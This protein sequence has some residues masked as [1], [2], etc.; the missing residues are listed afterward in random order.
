MKCL[1]PLCRFNFDEGTPPTNFDT[2][3]AA[4]MTVFQVQPSPSPM[5]AGPYRE[6]PEFI[7][8]QGERGTWAGAF[9]VVSTGRNGQ[10]TLSRLRI[11]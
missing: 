9:I 8:R 4:I 7:R 3:P 1:C 5:N 10:G 11:G 2:F 6:A